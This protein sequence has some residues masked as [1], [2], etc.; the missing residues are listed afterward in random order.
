MM[1]GS[2][3]AQVDTH[4]TRSIN[5]ERDVDSKQVLSAYIPTS[6][7]LQVVS[8]I[9]MTLASWKANDFNGI[10]ALATGAG[11]TITAIHAA[12]QL[13]NHQKHL[14]LVVA[15][16]YQNLAD[17]WCEVMELFSITAIRCYMSKSNWQLELSTAISD[18]NLNQTKPFL[19]I[20]VV[21]R[22]LSGKIFQKEIK[23]ITSDNLLFV[24]DECHHHSSKNV[25]KKLLDARFR[26][27]LSATPWS[28][29]E[30][31]KQE[32]L[33][34]YYGGI[35]TEYSIADALDDK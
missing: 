12:T 27:G 25:I 1:K 10:F 34:S 23:K 3:P 9:E 21:N 20:V 29:K 24:G 31:V 2:F 32:A 16:P 18:F 4:Y 7:A 28:S 22:T 15:V 11:K 13:A 19:A 35:V 17:Q 14:A 6:K 8:K 26:I 30:E 5:I 33:T